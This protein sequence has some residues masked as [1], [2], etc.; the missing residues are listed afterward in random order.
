MAPPSVHPTCMFVHELPWLKRLPWF[1]CE[2]QLLYNVWV[3]PSNRYV[4]EETKMLWGWTPSYP[5]LKAWHSLI[6]MA[7]WSTSGLQFTW[8]GHDIGLIRSG[9]LF[10]YPMLA[11]NTCV[12][13]TGKHTLISTWSRSQHVI[14]P[15]RFQWHQVSWI[16]AMWT[17]LHQLE[18]NGM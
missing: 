2:K 8:L 17:E 12:V 13:I 9:V 15:C 6:T 11:T 3:L 5:P 18:R 1:Q 14:I 10:K 16:H 4:C 7:A